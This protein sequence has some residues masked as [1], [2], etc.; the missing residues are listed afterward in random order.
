MIHLKKIQNDILW[1]IYT[2][3]S[4]ITREEYKKPIACSYAGNSKCGNKSI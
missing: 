1:K 2:I 3:I 4:F